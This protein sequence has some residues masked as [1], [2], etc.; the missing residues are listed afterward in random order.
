MSVRPE[1]LFVLGGVSQ[2]LGAAIAVVL[3]DTFAAGTVAL[4]RVAAA[5]VIVIIASRSWRR[6]WTLS[7]VK[8]AALFGTVLAGMNLAFYLA[9]E[10]LPIGNAVAIEFLGPVAVAAWGAKSKRSWFGLALAVFGVLTLAGVAP[11]G[12]LSGVL[13]ALVAAVLWA[14]YIVLGHRV[15]ESGAGVDG[16]GVGMAIGALAIAP[17]GFSGLA[18]LPMAPLLAVL[19]LATGLLSNAIPYALDQVVLKQ[20]TKARFALLESLLPVTATV[21]GAVAI[22]QIPSLPE[23]V[24]VAMVAV[25]IVVADLA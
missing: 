18:A 4:L 5:A 8:S 23:V 21:V 14:G 10:Q 1:P 2:Y 12:N 25:A 17:F 16:L 24:G 6:K 22:S 3:F 13:F 11:E 15:A 20:L 19:A 7:T 9:I